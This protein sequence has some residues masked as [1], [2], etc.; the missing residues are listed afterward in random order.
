MTVKLK[1]KGLRPDVLVRELARHAAPNENGGVT[2]SSLDYEEHFVSIFAMLDFRSDA[3]LL[4]RE[5]ALWGAIGAAIRDKNFDQD[6]FLSEVS[7]RLHEER[8]KKSER[9][10]LLTSMSIDWNSLPFKSLKHKDCSLRFFKT[11]PLKFHSRREKEEEFHLD[12]GDATP[13]EFVRVVV[14]TEARTQDDAAEKCIH[15]VTLLRALLC[16][17]FN[18]SMQYHFG[19]PKQYSYRNKVV[20]GCLHTVHDHNGV[21][22]DEMYWFE[23]LPLPPTSNLRIKQHDLVVTKK[24]LRFFFRQLAASRYGKEIEVALIRYVEGFDDP[25]DR[26]AIPK[27]WSAIEKITATT[28]AEYDRLIRRASAIYRDSE[29]HAVHLSAIREAR[30]AVVHEGARIPGADVHCFQLQSYFRGLVLFHIRAC[31]R[32]D[33][34]EQANTFLDLPKESDALK[35]RIGE[36]RRALR[37]RAPR[38]SR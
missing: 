34:L 17:E 28:N 33:N 13:R 25:D 35:A 31:R 12:K 21:S 4:S 16:M 24:N 18:S 5:S 22:P 20:T 23:K 3:T 9:Y 6:K 26:D 10:F 30:N 19:T 8:A 27:L 14:S 15:L 29:L 7:K 11:Y 36:L 1:R 38:D 32:Y 2:F 37:F